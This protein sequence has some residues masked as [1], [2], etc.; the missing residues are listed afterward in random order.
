[1]RFDH[2]LA[3]FPSSRFAEIRVEQLSRE[4]RVVILIPRRS[5]TSMKIPWRDIALRES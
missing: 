2:L 3:V 1:L 5:V 4:F